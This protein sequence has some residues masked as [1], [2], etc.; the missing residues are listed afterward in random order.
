MKKIEPEWSYYWYL[1][2][3]CYYYCQI[4]KQVQVGPK[5]SKQDLF[6]WVQTLMGG[7]CSATSEEA[8]VASCCFSQ[9]LLIVK[10]QHGV[11]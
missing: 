11:Y 4:S 8:E 6:L 7:F 3:V 2:E 9:L 1:V 10:Y 5:V